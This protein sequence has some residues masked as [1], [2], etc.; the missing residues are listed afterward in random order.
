MRPIR[1]ENP[2]PNALLGAVRHKRGEGAAV[3]LL[4]DLVEL[5]VGTRRSSKKTGRCSSR[6]SARSPRSMV[7]E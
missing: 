1:C 2:A 5:H 3:G 7:S 6:Q 4:E